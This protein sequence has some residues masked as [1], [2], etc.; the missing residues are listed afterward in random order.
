MGDLLSWSWGCRGSGGALSRVSS[1][2]S[3]TPH[4]SEIGTG[5]LGVEVE[6]GVA[7]TGFRFPTGGVRTVLSG[8][9]ER[10]GGEA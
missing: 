4:P 6:V 8:D 3:L 2:L 9:V 7:C 10:S 5:L 1:Y